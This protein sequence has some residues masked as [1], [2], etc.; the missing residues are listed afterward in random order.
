M[1]EYRKPSP[2]SFDIGAQPPAVAWTFVAGDTPAF[3]TL[4]TDE[5]RVPLDLTEWNLAMDIVRPSTG[6]VV[7]SVVPE[8]T[9]SDGPGEFTTSLTSEISRLCQTEDVF[10]IQISDTLRVWT[11]CKGSIK[12]IQD[13]TE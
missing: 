4:I 11:V 5:N 10:D 3:R 2:Q 7:A 13:I 12:V 9:A 8:I 6:S 1:T